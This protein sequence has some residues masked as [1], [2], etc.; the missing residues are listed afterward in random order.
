MAFR[1]EWIELRSGNPGLVIYEDDV[2]G[3]VTPYASAN[4]SGPIDAQ[5]DATGF[6]PGT[7]RAGA[8]GQE[9]REALS[10]AGGMA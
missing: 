1:V 10:P 3:V 4:R 8:Q 5:A 9:S 6:A 2:Q 7:A